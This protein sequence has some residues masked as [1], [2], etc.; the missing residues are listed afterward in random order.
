M[1]AFLALLTSFAFAS[2]AGVTSSYTNTEKDCRFEENDSPEAAGSDA[3]M[4]CKG[5]GGYHLG[6]SYSVF[7][8]FRY[9]TRD[10]GG[11]EPPL[12]LVPDNCP[13]AFFG[14]ITEWRL[15]DNVPFALIQR[16]TCSDQKEDGSGAGRMLGEWLVV[17]ELQGAK[18]K[19]LV[20]ASKTNANAKARGIADKF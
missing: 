4:D 10:G 2:H 7:S 14:K 11:S 19:S 17:Q 5:P 16:V 6:E 20:D 8:S 13:I 15:R 3:P 1:R 9:I 12:S 18:R